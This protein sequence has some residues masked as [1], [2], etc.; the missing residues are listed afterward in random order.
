[1]IIYFFKKV[2]Y[3]VFVLWG[4]L[5]L[6]FFLFNVLPG[7]PARMMLDKREDSNQLAIIK[8]KYA[9]DRS[10]VE[11]YALYLNDV[12]PF[13]IHNNTNTSFTYLKDGKYKFKRLFSFFDYTIVLKVPYLRE[14]FV[15]TG[16]PVGIILMNTFKNT[17]VLAFTSIFFALLLGL[18]LGPLVYSLLTNIEN[19]LSMTSSLPLIIIGGFF[20]GFGTKIGSGCTSGHGIC[21]I[22]RFS[23]RSILATISFIFLAMI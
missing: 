10:L 11:Q 18:V 9:F 5:T 17:F 16:T 2:T 4:V 23:V 20:V 1:M 8:Q 7:D 15:R 13:S 6:V 12:S 21:G 14:T 22:S 19:S 3:G